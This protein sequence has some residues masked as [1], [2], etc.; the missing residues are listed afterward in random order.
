MVTNDD[1]LDI[2]AYTATNPTSASTSTGFI[3][4]DLFH[5][6]LITNV[7]H[8]TWLINIALFGI[9]GTDKELMLVNFKNIS[10]KRATFH[11]WQLKQKIQHCRTGHQ[12]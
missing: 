9:C 12:Y 1:K 5:E 11:P 4:L 8:F 10:S 7:C 3:T 6:T 2:E